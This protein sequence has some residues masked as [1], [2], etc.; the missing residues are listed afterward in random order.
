[1]EKATV[2]R[3]C[4]Q[5]VDQKRLDEVLAGFS[6]FTKSKVGERPVLAIISFPKLSLDVLLYMYICS[7]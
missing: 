1:M 6:A 3:A 4:C 2:L 5:K 7:L